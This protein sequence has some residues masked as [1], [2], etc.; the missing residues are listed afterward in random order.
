MAGVGGMSGS[1]SVGGQGLTAR[2]WAPD[3]Y[4]GPGA[5]GSGGGFGAAP[6]TPARAATT[7]APR[8]ALPSTASRGFAV[9][10]PQASVQ[11]SPVTQS[12]LIGEPLPPAPDTRTLGAPTS[13]GR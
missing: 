12:T 5:M 8:Y 3:W 2:R 10:T 6:G 13:A 11:T 1:G 4:P 9:N 7:P